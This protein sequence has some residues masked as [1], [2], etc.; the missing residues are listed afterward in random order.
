[1]ESENDGCLGNDG[2]LGNYESSFIITKSRKR[3]EKRINSNV[4]RFFAFYKIY[5]INEKLKKNKYLSLDNFSYI[6]QKIN[7]S[8]S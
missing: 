6:L 2:Y 4:V 5:P 1:M 3:K 7:I 8:N